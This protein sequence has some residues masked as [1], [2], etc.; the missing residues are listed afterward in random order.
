MLSEVAG[1]K[2][3]SLVASYTGGATTPALSETSNSRHMEASIKAQMPPLQTNPE[4]PASNSRGK[5]KVPDFNE[6]FICFLCGGY[7]IEATT[8]NECMHSCKSLIDCVSI[9][10]INWNQ[11]NGTSKSSSPRPLHPHSLSLNSLSKLHRETFRSE[12]L[13]SRVF[14]QEIRCQLDWQR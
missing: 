12:A 8:I 14:P 9:E 1:H 2:M 6:F 11:F 13:L 10:N 7:K 5:L 4:T 3:I